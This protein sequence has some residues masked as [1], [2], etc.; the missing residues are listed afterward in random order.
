MRD[1]A[2]KW[3]ARLLPLAA[4]LVGLALIAALVVH[5]GAAAVGAALAAFGW[6]AFAAITAIHL[7]LIAVMGLAW[8]ELLPGARR[9]VGIWGRLVRDGAAEVLPL[10]QLGGY[11]LG[12]R[13]VALAGVAGAA[14]AGSTIVDVTLEFVAQLAYTGLGLASLI[15][16]QPHAA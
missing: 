3:R 16:L 7:G 11:V 10:S 8:R 14:A 12:A 6:R 1:G 2:H 9:W 5:I 4:A 13:A 15:Y